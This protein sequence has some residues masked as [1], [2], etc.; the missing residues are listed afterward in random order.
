MNFLVLCIYLQL[1]Q[2]TLKKYWMDEVIITATRYKKPVKDVVYSVDIVKKETIEN[3]NAYMLTDVIEIVAGVWV[4]KTGNFG[5]SDVII[6]GLGDKGRRIMVLVNGRPVKMG[7]FGCTV[8]HSL[9][10]NNIERVEIVKG[11]L[12]VLYGSDALGGIVNIITN[13]ENKTNLK[14]SYGSFNTLR[15]LLTH[16]AS[17]GQFN[18]FF[19]GSWNLSDGYQENSSYNGKDFTGKIEYK[20]N[21][22]VWIE[23][24]SKYFDGIKH[25]PK[26]TCDP[27]T[28]IPTAWNWYKRGAFDLTLTADW[29]ITELLLKFYR[30]FGNHEFSDGWK[31]TDYTNGTIFHIKKELFKNYFLMT[32]VEFREQGGEKL[33]EPYKKCSKKEY[34]GFVF[35]DIKITQWFG[36]T[37]GIRY[38]YDEFSKGCLSFT[39]GNV[40]NLSSKT[41]LHTN[42]SKGFRSPQLNELC[43]FPPSNENL[44]PEMVWNYEVGLGQKLTS[45]IG[46]DVTGYLMKGKDLIEF[47]PET[48]KFENIGEFTFKGIEFSCRLENHLL[49][50]YLSYSYLDPGEKTRGRMKHKLNTL[51]EIKTFK[52]VRVSISGKWVSKYYASD[53]HENRINDFFVLNS[54]IKYQITKTIQLF[55]ACDNLLDKKY[56]MYVDIP[57]GKAGTYLMPPRTLSAGVSFSL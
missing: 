17:L 3:I 39:A 25:E 26:R 32:G 45:N 7:L 47:N 8:T 21:D 34:A 51:T 33:S 5:R 13:T 6:R 12:S 46:F 49:N 30:N 38:N 44:K 4:E 48:S 1:N 2:D 15:G 27:D 37:Y 53:N 57:G 43:L 56:E 52:N 54:K 40:F 31:S 28:L 16:G 10:F 19:T 42:I 36:I 50:F 41:Y 9:P 22:H 24:F 18:Y 14:I 11:P 29:Q 35:N 20:F 55:F 23:L